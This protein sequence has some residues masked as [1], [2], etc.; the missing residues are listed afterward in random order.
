MVRRICPQCSSRKIAHKSPLNF[1][2]KGLSPMIR[3]VPKVRCLVASGWRLATVPVSVTILAAAA[4]R[5]ASPHPVLVQ[6]TRHPSRLRAGGDP[7]SHGCSEDESLRCTPDTRFRSSLVRSLEAVAKPSVGSFGGKEN[8]S[9]C[10]RTSKP[11][12]LP[13]ATTGRL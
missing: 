3:R 2:S 4:R 6:R 11:P 9:R 5:D 12:K 7:R 10:L 1:L 13:V 8:T